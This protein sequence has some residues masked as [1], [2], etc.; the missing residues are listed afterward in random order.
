MATVALTSETFEQTIRDN[1][2]V[3]LDFW[4][5]WCGP[6]KSFA[7]HYEA[8]SE[9]H[10]DVVFGKVDTE[11]QQALAQR[12]NIR[13]IPTVMAFRDEVLVFSQPGALPQAAL[14]ELVRQVK[15]LDMD[16]VRARIAEHEA[17][18]D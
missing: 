3:L 10:T 1:A 17:Q 16:E 11:D 4:A 7:P 18:H 12:F 13:S 2:I 14:Q 15:D 8:A 6:C 5:D 9:E